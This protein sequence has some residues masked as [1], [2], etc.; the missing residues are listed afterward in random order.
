MRGF[1]F[2]HVA[3]TR[4]KLSIQQFSTPAT[5][6]L[7]LNFPRRIACI[8]RL[9]GFEVHMTIKNY[10]SAFLKY[11]RSVLADTRELSTDIKQV[12][13]DKFLLY[14]KSDKRNDFFGPKFSRFVLVFV[15]AWITSLIKLVFEQISC[16]RCIDQWITQIVTFRDHI[17]VLLL[18]LVMRLSYLSSIRIV[19]SRFTSTGTEEPSLRYRYHSNHKA[20]WECSVIDIMK[21]I[22]LNK[23]SII[24]RGII[25]SNDTSYVLRLCKSKFDVHYFSLINREA[26]KRGIYA[27]DIEKLIIR[28]NEIFLKN[29]LSQA[30]IVQGTNL[31]HVIGINHVFPLSP[32]F[33]DL[34]KSG[35]Y[36]DVEIRSDHVAAPGEDWTH[37]LLFAVALFSDFRGKKGFGPAHIRDLLVTHAKAHILFHPKKD[38]VLSMLTQIDL[39]EKVLKAI[40]EGLGFSDTG[41]DSRDHA[42]IF[43][44]TFIID[45]VLMP[46][47]RACL[48]PTVQRAPSA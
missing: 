37:I 22:E 46:K 44:Y 33:G 35:A 18:V 10:R 47:E 20:L 39:T 3:A 34:Y 29:N 9:A 27:Y 15:F 25:E 30:L 23:E 24:S 32:I 19:R 14:V 2:Q 8:R 48:P 38:K 11:G 21:K 42:R 26:F 7:M 13:R 6:H 5:I 12:F 36:S 31:D 40:I 16:V 17:I 41:V 28:N 43:E 1:A 4:S 45:D